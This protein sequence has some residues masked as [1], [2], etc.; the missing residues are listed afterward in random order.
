M[1]CRFPGGGSGQRPPHCYPG[2]GLRAFG[3]P[4]VRLRL[5]IQSWAPGLRIEKPGARRAEPTVLRRRRVTSGPG[6]PRCCVPDLAP[7]PWSEIQCYGSATL[8]PSMVAVKRETPYV[9]SPAM[10]GLM[11]GCG[12]FFHN[13]PPFGNVGLR[14]RQGT[15]M[16]ESCNDH[17]GLKLRVSCVSYAA[18][19]RRSSTVRLDPALSG[20][21]FRG[22]NSTDFCFAALPQI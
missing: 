21:G 4:E 7:F 22:W 13:D 15:G 10:T 19:K 3:A 17:R 6:W 11:R 18:L 20:P 5:R 1:I 16:P 12:L 8:L 14:L 9:V 2:S